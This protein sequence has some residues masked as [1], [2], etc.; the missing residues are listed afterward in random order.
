MSTSLLKSLHD[1]EQKPIGGCFNM[2]PLRRK[3][4]NWRT[5]TK[6]TQ[7]DRLNPAISQSISTADPVTP[8]TPPSASVLSLFSLPLLSLQRRRSASALHSRASA[9]LPRQGNA[10]GRLRFAACRL[11][12][13][14]TSR[15]SPFVARDFL[16]REK[17]SGSDHQ[18]IQ[19]WCKLP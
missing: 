2:P 6:R 18:L 19:S 14:A 13:S 3:R 4:K 11:F 1:T 9:Q 15:A 17:R 8:P 16:W 5:E 7:T 10:Q 12:K